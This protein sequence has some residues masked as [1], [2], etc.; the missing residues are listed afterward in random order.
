MD[1]T[2][3]A[4]DEYKVPPLVRSEVLDA[5]ATLK[6]NDMVAHS[7]FSHFSPTGV[8]PWHWFDEAGYVYAYAGENLAVHFTDSSEMVAAWMDSPAHK[9]NIVNGVYTEIGLGTARGTFEGYDTVFVVQLFGTPGIPILPEETVA[10]VVPTTASVSKEM[11]ISSTTPVSPAVL[12][13]TYTATPLAASSDDPQ[14]APG[15]LIANDQLP[16]MSS[17]TTVTQ[18]GIAL[19]PEKTV[20]TY[21]HNQTI[22]SSSLLATSSGLQVAEVT[23]RGQS[24]ANGISVGMLATQ[25]NTILQL[26]YMLLGG[27]TTALLLVSIVFEVRRLQYV[28]VLYSLLL[29]GGMGVLWYVHAVL[30]A[31]AVVT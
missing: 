16:E 17:A 12:A 6:A 31:G 30:T 19:V 7:Y 8:S 18:T 23:P 25:P 21:Y 9:E 24:Y 4:R 28:Q 3:E 15:V 2:N 26:L 20:T 27:V 1:L 10:S 5:A 29:L 13:E 14:T 11:T 22:I